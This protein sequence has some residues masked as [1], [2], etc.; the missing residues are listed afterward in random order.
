MHDT[1]L[2]ESFGNVFVIVHGQKPPSSDDWNEYTR[3]LEAW[4]AAD[5]RVLVVTDGAGP[6]T[7]Q[8]RVLNALMAKTGKAYRV[9]V[10]TRSL[11]ARSVVTA[12]GWLNPDIR[13]FAPEEFE[14]ALDYLVVDGDLRK[15]MALRVRAMRKQLAGGVQSRS[16]RGPP[17][18]PG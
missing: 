6:N 8:R 18:P 15:A 2:Y 9:A 11:V 16:A 3:S 10:V 7:K 17:A 5:L 4:L 12:L 1:M 14:L 13:A